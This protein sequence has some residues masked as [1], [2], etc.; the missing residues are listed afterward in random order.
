MTKR[1]FL[2]PVVVCSLP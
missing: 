2:W 1:H